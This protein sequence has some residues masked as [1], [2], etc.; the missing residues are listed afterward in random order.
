MKAV[1]LFSGGID[2]ATTLGLALKECDEVIALQAWYGS[3]HNEVERNSAQQ[4]IKWYQD[5]GHK[6]TLLEVQLPDIF[7]GS[8][9]ALMGES[10][11]PHLTYKQIEEGEGP[12]PTVVPFRNANLLAVAGTVAEVHNAAWIYAGMHAEDARGWAYPD[13]TFEF[14]GAFANALFVGTNNKVR[15]KTPFTWAMKADIV[16]VALNIGVPIELTWSC[17]SPVP[18]ADQDGERDVVGYEACGRCPTC[19]E[20]IE[21]FKENG[22]IDPTFYAVDIDWGSAEAYEPGVF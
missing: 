20:R 5:N 16:E 14:L 19:I 1:C 18:V 12:S 11:M 4:V 2:S 17:Y 15:L 10:E 21:A 8:N 6:V 22:V 9:S 3:K 7:K 13:C